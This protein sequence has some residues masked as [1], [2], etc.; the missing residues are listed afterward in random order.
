MFQEIDEPSVDQDLPSWVELRRT[1]NRRRGQ[2][3]ALVLESMQIEHGLLQ[4]QGELVLL[5]RPEDAARADL[6]CERYERENVG[7]PPRG[8]AQGSLSEG[9]IG[10]FGWVAILSVVEILVRTEALGLDWW[11][12]GRGLAGAITSGEVWRTMTGLSLHVD[13]SHFLSNLVFGALFTMLICEL[14]G[15]GLGL[16]SI[17]L[18]GALGN[19]ANALLQS[20]N[21]ASVGAS[22]AVFAAL[23]MLVSYQFMRRHQLRQNAF[24]RWA[25]LL[26]GGFLLASLGLTPDTREGLGRAVDF[27][28]HATGF[29]AGALFG[30][31]ISLFQVRRLA[32]PA[33]QTSTLVLAP[34]LVAIAWW[35]AF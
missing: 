15:A 24:R 26:A 1:P 34:A 6:E 31:V 10:A 30:L 4:Q 35:L 23:G 18:A 21:H 3:L 2:E 25:P 7:W 17:L 33:L 14:I 13:L 20:P 9:L 28:A 12:Q 5:V 19:F 16:S 32:S 8:E 22:T 11:R 29:G 27:G